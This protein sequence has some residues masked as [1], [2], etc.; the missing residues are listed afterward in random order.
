MN[1]PS[2]GPSLSTL[3]LIVGPALIAVAVTAVRAF[4]EVHGWPKPLV[5]SGVCGKAILGVAWLVPVFGVYFALG[6]SRAG[7]Q[8][9][10]LVPAALLAIASVLLKLGGTAIM[11]RPGLG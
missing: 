6:L 11:E 8:P 1:Q 2:Q 4:G 7:S 9:K 5:N 10:P 3:R